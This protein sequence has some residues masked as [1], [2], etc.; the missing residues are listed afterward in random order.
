M[1][2]QLVLQNPKHPMH[3]L[4]NIDDFPL[5]GAFAEEEPDALEHWVARSLSL[6]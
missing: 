5:S 4:I 2:V 1:V 6:G 3:R